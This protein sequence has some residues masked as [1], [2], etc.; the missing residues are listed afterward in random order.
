MRIDKFLK[1]SRL[2][3]R[4]E[5]AKRL[6]EDGDVFINGKIAKAS[7]EIETGDRLELHLGRRKVVALIKEIRPYAAK[8]VASS[9]YEIV[10]EEEIGD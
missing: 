1:V 2:V 6:C 4:R 9:L 3:L 8:S 5:V 10:S 7:S